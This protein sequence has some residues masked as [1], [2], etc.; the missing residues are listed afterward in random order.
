MVNG[1]IQFLGIIFLGLCGRSTMVVS[2]AQPCS[3]QGQAPI[4]GNGEAPVTGEITQ[5]PLNKYKTNLAL[6][7]RRATVNGWMRKWDHKTSTTC[8][9][10]QSRQQCGTTG[11]HTRDLDPSTGDE[12]C[13]TQHLAWQHGRILQGHKRVLLSGWRNQG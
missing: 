5:V 9:Q 10:N 12:A 8:F 13:E 4:W 1:N 7:S 6:M 2:T 3:G 11:S